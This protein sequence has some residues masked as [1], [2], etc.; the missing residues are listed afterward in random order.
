MNNQVPLTVRT[1]VTVDISAWL[2]FQFWQQVLY[3]DHEETW[4]AT[5]ERTGR[6]VGVPENIG[7]KLTY[8]IL[9]EQS[10]RLLA[11][12]VVCPM[13]SNHCVKFD[14]SLNQNLKR[15][16]SNGGIYGL[17]QLP[18]MTLTNMMM[19]RKILNHTILTPY[20]QMMVLYPKIL[21]S[22]EQQNPLFAL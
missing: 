14:P 3:L 19:M 18:K 10:K 15:S 9:D 2:Q 8:W 4:P 22:E 17:L 11:C 16:A 13:H 6:W 12:S 20:N 21:H 7:D 1:G 5:K